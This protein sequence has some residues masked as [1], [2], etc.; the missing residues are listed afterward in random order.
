M[1][2]TAFFPFILVAASSLSILS[3][4]GMDRATLDYSGESKPGIWAT[5]SN[6]INDD[7][8]NSRIKGGCAVSVADSNGEI[9]SAGFGKADIVHGISFS[10]D[11][12]SNVGSVSKLFTATAVM[13]LVEAG[14]IDLDAPITTYLP[15]LKPKTRFP[16][17]RPITVRDV[18][19][20][21]SGLPS[22]YL[23]GF[24][25]GSVKPEDYP[26]SF[27]KNAE[28]ASTMY[29][30]N[31]PGRVFSYSNLS[32]AM[33]G[34]IVE[35]ISGM[36]FEA[37]CR[38]E[39]FQP[40]GMKDTSFVMPEGFEK[41]ARFAKGFAKGKEIAIPYIRD[42]P[43]GALHSNAHDLARF[44]AFY[45][46]AYKGKEGILSSSTVKEMFTAQNKGIEADLS[47]TI[48]LNFFIFANDSLLP[49]E[50]IVGHDGALSTFYALFLLL[51]ERG[52]AVSIL[53]NSPTINLA[54]IVDQTLHAAV[55][56]VGGK[57][58]APKL[59]RAA[60]APMPIGE[61]EALSG[62]YAS[63]MGLIRLKSDG[64][65]LKVNIMDRWFN[66]VW[67][68][69]STISIEKRILGIKIPINQL[70]ALTIRPE[71]L[72][73]KPALGLG[74]LGAATSIAV[75]IDKAPIPSA[76]KER[77]GKYVSE[78]RSAFVEG[79]AIRIGIDKDTGL[80]M[81]WLN[82]RMGIPLRAVSDSECV[83]EGLGRN[84]GETVE[85]SDNALIF[86]G[87]KLIK[88]KR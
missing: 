36:S 37:F 19:T 28:L 84:L 51:P 74:S 16:E 48:G 68:T 2:C 50:F 1:K 42:I 32:V 73:G 63:P 59:Q 67:H 26:E 40:L 66:G 77:I 31:P 20:H 71:K 53:T 15:E 18:M 41:D 81:A 7:V 61:S 56:S 79:F 30:A 44:A 14:G 80:L 82:D 24:E 47:K 34:I 27:L 52:L 6:N 45:L 87:L 54:G 21:H 12:I 75:R 78:E 62:N 55:Q 83:I 39:I 88:S 57:P 49:G 5:L 23:N 11:T 43:A 13:K 76:W 4:A 58:F 46:G 69:D 60:A 10:P 38:Q 85:A 9:W 65:E 25:S 8:K 72:D 22:D 17:A 70:N 86:E 29:V 3:C 35:R 33:L 64:A